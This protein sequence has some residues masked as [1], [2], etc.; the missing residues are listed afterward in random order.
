MLLVLGNHFLVVKEVLEILHEVDCLPE[1]IEYQPVCGQN[2]LYSHLP[3]LEMYPI[4]VG[5]EWDTVWLCSQNLA[6]LSW[7]EGQ[8]IQNHNQAILPSGWSSSFL[9]SLQGIT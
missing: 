8:T 3:E 7:L 1:H 2:Y 9:H 5:I 6:H 4:I